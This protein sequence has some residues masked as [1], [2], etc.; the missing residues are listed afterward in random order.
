MTHSFFQSKIGPAKIFHFSL[1]VV[2]LHVSHESCMAVNWDHN[3][4]TTLSLPSFCEEL[5]SQQNK[6][7]PAT[8]W[9]KMSN[10]LLSETMHTPTRCFD[11]VT[12]HHDHRL[13][14][15][16]AS[17][18]ILYPQKSSK[19]TSGVQNCEPTETQGWTSLCLT[20]TLDTSWLVCTCSLFGFHFLVC[21]ND[22]LIFS[23]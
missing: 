22:S 9:P 13:V 23:V 15:K 2:Q 14:A 4:T 12:V 10:F 3:D 8:K 6:K 11:T 20:R 5:L 17:K 21:C 1:I 16:M 18:V 7:F 19:L